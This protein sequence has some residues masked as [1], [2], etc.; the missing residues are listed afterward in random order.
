M[1][2]TS[3]GAKIV[4]YPHPVIL[5][6]ANVD[7]KPN[8]ST[9]AFCGI[10]NGRPPMVSVSFQHHR[11]T[12]K[13]LKQTGT[14]SVNIPS[15]D[16]VREVDFCGIESGRQTDKVAR[17][18]FDVFYGRLENAPM[19][20]Q[21]PVNMECQVVSITDLGSHEMVVGQIEEV[22]VTDACLSD[23]EP[24]VAKVRPFLWTG[25]PSNRFLDFGKEIGEAY[26]AGKQM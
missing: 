2:K 23:G 17:C 1:S 16:V 13:G 10:V 9:Y 11:H 15:V 20:G 8:F 24:D 5:A 3:I 18:N 26:K 6:G 22:Y 7:G 14:F 25:R 12:L 19:V 4:F 21:C